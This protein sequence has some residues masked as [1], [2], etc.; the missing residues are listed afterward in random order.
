MGAGGFEDDTSDDEQE[1]ARQQAIAK[2]KL[3]KKKA[4]QDAKTARDKAN[5][6]AAEARVKEAADQRAKE[7]QIKAEKDMAEKMKKEAM[8][9]L[10]G[11]TRN[12]KFK[13]K[14][15]GKAHAATHKKTWKNFLNQSE[16]I[17]GVNEVGSEHDLILG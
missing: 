3:D 4:D 7:A 10:L 15:N 12:H 2:A 9:A 1:V 16:M 6:A 13:Q 14:N 17:R 8:N 5:A 11:G